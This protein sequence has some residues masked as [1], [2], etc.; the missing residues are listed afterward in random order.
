[1]QTVVIARPARIV[2]LEQARRHLRVDASDDDGYIDALVLAAQQ[3]IDGPG[4]WLRGALGLQTLEL[5]LSGS[6]FTSCGVRL[7]FPPFVDLVSIT[8]DDPDGVT[9]THPIDA[10]SVQVSKDGAFWRLLPAYGQTFPAAR[11][12][13]DAVRI[14]YRAGYEAPELD[15][16]PAQQAMLV[17]HWYSNRAPVV[18]GAIAELPMAVEALLATY[19]VWS[20]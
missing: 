13:P 19:R 18:A 14:R 12:W 20:A 3:H 8:Y 9:R 16:L 7:P 6:D 11:C 5:R 4:G 10:A 2:T 15:L 1:M 17:E